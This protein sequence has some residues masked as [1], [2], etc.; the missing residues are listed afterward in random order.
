M[1]SNR[2]IVAKSREIG[3]DMAINFLPYYTNSPWL[4]GEESF[5]F[6]AIK[7]GKHYLCKYDVKNG[8]AKIVRHLTEINQYS[9]NLEYSS[10]L[11]LCSVVL[12][13][14][15]Q[16][17]IP[18][19]NKVF[20]L[21]IDNDSAPE[22]L[23][24]YDEKYTLGGLAVDKSQKYL[25]ARREIYKEQESLFVFFNLETRE[26]L[27]EIKMPFFSNHMQFLD[28]PDWI[29]FAHEGPAQEV[30]DRVNIFNWK[31]GKILNAYSQQHNTKGELVEF[32]GHEMT[33]GNKAVVVRY[34]VSLTKEFGLVYIDLL[35]RKGEFIDQDDYWHSSI[36]A[37]GNR[38][39][40]DTMWWGNSSRNKE[41][42]SDIVM[43]DND[44]KE[45]FLLD[46]SYLP[47]RIQCYHPHPAGTAKGDKVLFMSSLQDSNTDGC[48]YSQ[49]VMLELK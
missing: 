7:E 15:N 5:V 19:K 13:E 12:P 31:T 30:P 11:C 6:F 4:K 24:E 37:S 36:T 29:M 27:K 41:N 49:I 16:I 20:T 32:L 3:L 10:M 2:E 25:V 17:V 22:L 35:K 21:G 40:M 18:F 42:Y 44:T 8:T 38:F 23:F 1:Y 34:P 45:K 46:T 33:A 43:F 39:F 47:Y 26:I 9:D 48:P 28:D 14:S